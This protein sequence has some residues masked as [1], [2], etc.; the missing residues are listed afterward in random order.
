MLETAFRQIF[1]KLWIYYF[2]KQTV[3]NFE[4]ICRNEEPLQRV[5]RINKGGKIMATGG[6]DGHVRLW[7]FPAMKLIH[8]IAAHTKEIDDLDFSP[9][10]KWVSFFNFL[11]GYVIFIIRTTIINWSK[12]FSK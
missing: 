5:V 8:D 2:Y 4:L 12:H 10:D 3:Y 9:D 7:S 6:I 1:C 11:L